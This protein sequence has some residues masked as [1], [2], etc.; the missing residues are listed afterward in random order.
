[1]T[2]PGFCNIVRS[3]SK[4]PFGAKGVEV[5]RKHLLYQTSV[6][7]FDQTFTGPDIVTYPAVGEPVDQRSVVHNVSAEENLP[8]FVV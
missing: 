1:M 3:Q 4:K 6:H 7:Q 5:P 8:V 2:D